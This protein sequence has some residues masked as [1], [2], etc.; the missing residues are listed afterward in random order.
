[1]SPEPIR[2]EAPYIQI[3][4]YYREQILTGEIADGDKLPSITELA[5]NWHVANATAAKAISLLQVEKLIHSSPRGTFV[6]LSAHR[7]ASSPRDRLLRIRQIGQDTA[8]EYYQVNSAEIVKPPV[9]V[10][11]LFSL[12]YPATIIR[13]EWRTISEHRPVAF[14]V[15]WYPAEFAEPIP[16]LLDGRNSKVPGL[17][18][19]IEQLTGPLGY[20]R[21]FYEAREADPREAN[22]LGIRLASPILAGVFLRFPESDPNRLVEYGEFCLPPGRVIGYEYNLGRENDHETP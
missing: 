17:T 1:M 14:S 2:H 6:D 4:N 16:D 20:A 5:E 13:R 22:G 18:R 21:D 15:S 3:A 10:A 19:Q 8:E 7:A 12:E 9:Y 11:E